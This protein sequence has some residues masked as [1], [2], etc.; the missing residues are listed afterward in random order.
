MDER[1]KTGGPKTE[2]ENLS[3]EVEATRTKVGGVKDRGGRLSGREKVLS[4]VYIS[5]QRTGTL[6]PLDCR[7][8]VKYDRNRKNYVRPL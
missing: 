7:K 3:V 8:K 5:R 4:T 1:S 6:K 2:T